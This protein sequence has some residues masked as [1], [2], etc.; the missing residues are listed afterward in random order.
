MTQE[1]LYWIYNCCSP[2]IR[3]QSNVN[4]LLATHSVSSLSHINITLL[5]VLN[6]KFYSLS[7]SSYRLISQ[8]HNHRKGWT[9]CCWHIDIQDRKMSE[10]KQNPERKIIWKRL[11][12]DKWQKRCVWKHNK[13]P[14]PTACT[15]Q[16]WSWEAGGFQIEK[17]PYRLFIT[18]FTR[19][20]NI[21]SRTYRFIFVQKTWI[22]PRASILHCIVSWNA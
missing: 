4:L 22:N 7:A 9:F 13:L 17:K 2:F 15:E 5:P 6:S 1:V 14:Q 11:F 21:Q 18:V 10:L 12:C 16:N 19:S 8:S 20:R 3:K